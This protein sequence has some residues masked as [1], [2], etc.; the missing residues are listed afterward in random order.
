M[1]VKTKTKK[2]KPAVLAK[3]KAVTL[4]SKPK[5]VR[6]AKKIIVPKVAAVKKAKANAG[7][8]VVYPLKLKQKAGHIPVK[9]AE[10]IV[11]GIKLKPAAN[12]EAIIVPLRPVVTPVKERALS[13][14]THTPVVKG[15]IPP[16]PVSK[17]VPETVVHK[18]ASGAPRTKV[19][20]SLLERRLTPAYPIRPGGE[21][22]HIP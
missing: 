7:K 11:E 15:T 2:E 20:G 12:P 17:P 6:Q 19:R 14:K 10:K 22:K 21:A 5:A 3:K 13:I 8:A 9:K 16:K 18:P 1:A 4:S